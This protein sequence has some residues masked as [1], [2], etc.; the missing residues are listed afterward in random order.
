MIRPFLLAL[1]F[2]TRIPTPN[3]KDISERDIGLSQY[4]YPL[5]GLI[6]GLI[7]V[8][9]SQLISLPSSGLEAALLLTIWVLITGALHIDGLADC[10]DAWVGGYGDKEK[11]L[12]IMKDPQSGPIAVTLVVCVLLIKFAA[13]E[14][15]ITNEAW[16]ALI[17]APVISRSM[18]PLL[19]QT[20]PYV[21]TKGLGSA[22]T[23][24]RSTSL[25]V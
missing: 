5:I 13:I 12:S 4:Y 14:A 22:L 7:L 20:T 9:S 16:T 2:L 18:L 1:Q 15:I 6:I 10:A 24:H 3:L 25:H 11:T 23:Q 8:V 19:F 17:L 21:R